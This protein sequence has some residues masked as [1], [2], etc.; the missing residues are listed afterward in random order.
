MNLCLQLF[1]PGVPYSP[2]NLF[3]W[4]KDEPVRVPSFAVKSVQARVLFCLCHVLVFYR[5]EFQSGVVLCRTLPLTRSGFRVSR[6]S[7]YHVCVSFSV[8]YRIY[9]SLFIYFI[10]INFVLI[11]VSCF[12]LI[13]R[14]TREASDAMWLLWRFQGEHLLW[15]FPSGIYGW[16]CLVGTIKFNK[17]T[18]T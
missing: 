15:T 8:V 9:I 16:Y 14:S 7:C 11:S 3:V 17:Q 1:C 5:R 13:C 2:C 4:H 12:L 18:Q 10:W 6:L